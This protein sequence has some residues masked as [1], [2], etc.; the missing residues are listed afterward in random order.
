MKVIASDLTQFASTPSPAHAYRLSENTWEFPDIVNKLYL[1]YSLKVT[2][3]PAW[4][5]FKSNKFVFDLTKYPDV[6]VGDK[7]EIWMDF[8]L[9]SSK[10]S[11]FGA[12]SN[13][14]DAKAFNQL[15]VLHL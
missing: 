4:A 5:S 2:K 6:Q 7:F 15:Y 13:N 10:G 14:D 12:P 9:Q 8:N 3:K 1:E 11:Y